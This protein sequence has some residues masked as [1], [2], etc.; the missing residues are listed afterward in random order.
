MRQP[1]PKSFFLILGL[2]L[3]SLLGLGQAC[4]TAA[5]ERFSKIKESMNKDEVL[6]LVGSP[7][8]TEQF[9]GKEKWAYRYYN[10]DKEELRQVTFQNGT[11]V[12][13]G[14]DTAELSRIKD[15]QKGDETR[16]K[17]RAATKSQSIDMAPADQNK[18]DSAER[19]NLELKSSDLKPADPHTA[20]YKEMK[21][22]R[23]SSKKTSDQEAN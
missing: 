8:R 16:A 14:E 22:H 19:K 6:D 7:N 23:G 5:F 17:K 12:S 9:D 15:I 20:E 10:S 21:G 11:V 2:M 13:F 18:S 3:V 1:I 4:Q